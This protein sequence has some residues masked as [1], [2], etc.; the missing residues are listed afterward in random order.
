MPSRA[1]LTGELS[2]TLQFLGSWTF[3][4]LLAGALVL[5][6]VGYLW[7][8]RVAARRRPGPPWPARRTTSFLIGLALVWVVTLG[9][10]GAYDDVFFWSHMAQH[11]VLMMV[12]APL[13][14]LGAP[15][16]LALR[17]STRAFRRAW[18]LP[19][20]NGRVVAFLT[21]PVASWV[22][23][24]GVLMGTHFSPFYEFALEHPN[25]H[26]YLEHP[27]YL[28]A[29]ILFYWPLLDGNPSRRKLPHVGRVLS[30]FL[31]M[32]PETM[33]GFFIYSAGH[34]LYPFYDSVARPFGPGPLRDQQWGG[35]LM[36]GGSMVIDTVW[37]AVAALAW[38]RHEERR[39][40]RVDQRVARE[41]AVAGPGRS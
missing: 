23:F 25:V 30:M 24:A 9:P 38:Y 34:V 18:I 41:L 29:G 22:I 3:D 11:I 33:T 5:A 1:R 16:L 13:L 19:V 32:A 10:I 21:H 39:A 28:G 12:A 35:A 36:W 37:I 15:I 40:V 26:N 2:P 27:L 20:L 14:M 6:G 17:A 4:P 31:M 7:G 8:V